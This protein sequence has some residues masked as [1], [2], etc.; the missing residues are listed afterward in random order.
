MI[1]KNIIQ[2]NYNMKYIKLFEYFLDRSDFNYDENL[3]Y[4]LTNQISHIRSYQTSGKSIS[5]MKVSIEGGPVLNFY[6]KNNNGVTRFKD[7]SNQKMGTLIKSQKTSNTVTL[8]LQYDGEKNIKEFVVR[9]SELS[10]QLPKSKF[11]P[12]GK[13][14]ESI[15]TIQ[16]ALSQVDGGKYKKLLGNFGPNRDGIDGQYGCSTLKAIIQ[17]QKDNKIEPPDGIYG[18]N[19]SEILSQKLG[20]H[21]PPHGIQKREKG[22]DFIRLSPLVPTEIKK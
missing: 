8:K 12:P 2:K 15:K 5:S 21:I 18:P 22:D 6:Q 11:I 9:L 10:C 19:T 17:F 13:D 3:I 7:D 1:E 20:E 4:L 14:I 16:R